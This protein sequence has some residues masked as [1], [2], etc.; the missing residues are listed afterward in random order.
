MISKK[1]T[2]MLCKEDISKIENYDKA[3]AD[4]TQ[5]WVLHHRDECK[6]L[7]SG[8]KVIRSSAELKENGHYYNCPAN[9][10]IFLTGSEHTRLHNMFRSEVSEVS[11]ETRKKMSESHKGLKHTEETRKKMSEAHKGIPRSEEI[12]RKISESKK[13]KSTWNKCKATSVFGQAFKEHY[14]ITRC[15]NEKLYNK[16]YKYFKRYG[17]F[18]WN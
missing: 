9:E 15:D 4:T 5:I 12:R 16:E 17:K 14:G 10:L 18:S 6:I 2:K 13:G 8:I 1:Y 3:V 11:E 7:P